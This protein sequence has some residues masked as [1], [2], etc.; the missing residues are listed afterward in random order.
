[1]RESGR[2]ITDLTHHPRPEPRQNEGRV[3]YLAKLHIDHPACAELMT[4][5]LEHHPG[6][7]NT[8]RRSLDGL[9][10]RYSA[11]A[12]KGAA[13]RALRFRA[14]DIRTL[15]RILLADWHNQGDK[16]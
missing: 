12:L 10:S 5:I 14:Y 8:A 3:A 7:F 16:S 9:I 6:H 2:R 4:C 11:D 1:M 13:E 15:E